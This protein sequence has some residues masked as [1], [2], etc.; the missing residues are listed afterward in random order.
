[1]AEE[2]HAHAAAAELAL[3]LVVRQHFGDLRQLIHG[4]ASR[5]QLEPV[6]TGCAHNCAPG[7]QTR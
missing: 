1:M 6:W 2:D 7:V 5:G 4:D 3:E